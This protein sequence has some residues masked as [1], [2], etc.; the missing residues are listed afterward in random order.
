[1]PKPAKAFSPGLSEVVG[2][3]KRLGL[4]EFLIGGGFFLVVVLVM[5][6]MFLLEKY[7]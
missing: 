4:R 6:V 3:T 5:V 1:V 7:V 2:T